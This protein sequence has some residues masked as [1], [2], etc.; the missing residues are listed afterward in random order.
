MGLTYEELEVEEKKARKSYLEAFLKEH[1]LTEKDVKQMTE[2]TG[3]AI[4]KV[5]LDDKGVEQYILFKRM[6]K[7][8]PFYVHIDYNFELQENVRPET[9]RKKK[10]AKKAKK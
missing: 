8:K 5:K 1:N 6:A 9:N 2:K 3:Y 10:R 4:T 7:S